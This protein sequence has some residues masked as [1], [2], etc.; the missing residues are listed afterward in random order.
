[1]RSDGVDTR[2]PSESDGLRRL[3]RLSPGA[4]PGISMCIPGAVV[5]VLTKNRKTLP[6]P[7]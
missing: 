2:E 1:M 5:R 7:S 3:G 6:S 4:V